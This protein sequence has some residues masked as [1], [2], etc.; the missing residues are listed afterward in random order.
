M[1]VLVGTQMLAKGLILIMLVW[2]IMNADNML[3]FIQILEHLRSFQMMTQV[4]GRAG[5]AA[6]Q[7]KVVIQ[8]YNPA[9]N[10][11]QQV[12]NTDYVGM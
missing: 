10:T 7:G 2:L 6:K 3:K 12:T 9:H 1:D 4:A 5:R 11:I 8:T